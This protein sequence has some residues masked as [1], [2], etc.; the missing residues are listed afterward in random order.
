MRN[1]NLE[2]LVKCEF[3]LNID[4]IILTKYDKKSYPNRIAFYTNQAPLASFP[5]QGTKRIIRQ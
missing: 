4:L 5:Y 3:T 2:K 1:E